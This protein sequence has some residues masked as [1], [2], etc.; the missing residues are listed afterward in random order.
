M[1]LFTRKHCLIPKII[2]LASLGLA[3]TRVHTA[4]QFMMVGVSLVLPFAVPLLFRL[5]KLKMTDKMMLINLTFIYFASLVGSN[6]G[7]YGTAM[8]DKVVHFCSGLIMMELGLMIF[9]GWIGTQPLFPA[10]FTFKYF[11]MNALN[12]AVGTLWEFYEYMML[13]LFNNDCINHYTTGIHDSMTDL[14]CCFTAGLLFTG[15]SIYY[16]KHHRQGPAEAL[17]QEFFDANPQL[18]HSEHP[19]K[20]RIV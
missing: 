3:L 9:D 13:V 7:G 10:Q 18:I 8:F 15:I 1:N 16:H 14:L 11:F 17:S 20:R 5:L 6:L 2:Y 19:E 4:Y 12:L